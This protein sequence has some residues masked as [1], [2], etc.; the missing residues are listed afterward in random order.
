MRWKLGERNQ[1]NKYVQYQNQWK[2]S[3]GKR[4]QEGPM[5]RK[6]NMEDV[7]GDDETREEEYQRE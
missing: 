6:G 4:K 7:Q 1:V 5:I 2:K 3:L